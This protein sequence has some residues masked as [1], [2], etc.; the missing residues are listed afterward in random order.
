MTKNVELNKEYVLSDMRV[1]FQA[2]TRLV[3]NWD[4][5]AQDTFE[6]FIADGGSWN[7][8]SLDEVHAEIGAYI[9]WLASR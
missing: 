4:N 3:N 2:L 6:Q 8:P 9:N 1:M 7:I 5:T